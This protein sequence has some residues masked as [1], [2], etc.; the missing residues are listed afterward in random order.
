M[1]KYAIGLLK[2]AFTVGALVWL[3]HRIGTATLVESV[4][5]V[6]GKAIAVVATLATLQALLSAIRWHLILRYLGIA[7]VLARSMQIY[8]IGMFATALL[9]GGVAGDGLRIWMLVRS[10]TELSPA[11]NSVLLDRL[12]A[13][14]GLI[15][16]IAVGLPYV[17]DRIA[18]AHIR[19][20]V[21]AVLLVGLAAAFA[22]G[23]WIRIPEYWLRFRVIRAAMALLVD[24]RTL[25]KSSLHAFDL[26]CLSMLSFIMAL[27]VIFVLFRSLGAPVGAI[28]TMTLGSLVILAVTLPISLGG[29]GLREGTMVGLFGMIGIPPTTSLAV[30]VVVG[31]LSTA[32]SAPGLIFWLRWRY[33]PVRVRAEAASPGIGVHGMKA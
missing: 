23:L 31:L 5:S 10:G 27:L 4:R 12:A 22:I 1:K 16:L 9:P 13:L 6:P 8:W 18:P 3:L 30:S 11:V 15:L 33:G 17:D 32:V 20:A 29:W 19:L 28:E 26:I 24:F 2:A 21:S 14:A 25:C 7:V